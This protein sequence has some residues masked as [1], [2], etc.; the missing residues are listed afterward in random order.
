MS[1]VRYPQGY[2]ATAHGEPEEPHMCSP[3]VCPTCKKASYSGCGNHAAQVLANVPHD[4]RC[5]CR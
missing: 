2:T 3:A 4:Q 5:S 1:I